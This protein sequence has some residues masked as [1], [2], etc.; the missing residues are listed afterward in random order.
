[1]FRGALCVETSISCGRW[2]HAARFSKTDLEKPR[3]PWLQ[4]S[5]LGVLELHLATGVSSKN[6]VCPEEPKSVR[7]EQLSLLLPLLPSLSRV[8]TGLQKPEQNHMGHWWNA[9]F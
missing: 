9:T 3:G 6:Q 2:S 4:A 1:M 5:L 7:P 8:C